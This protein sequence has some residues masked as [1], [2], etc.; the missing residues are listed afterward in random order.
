MDNLEENYK[1]KKLKD[2]NK[3]IDIIITITIYNSFIL[4]F[5]ENF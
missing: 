4:F 2:K 5:N 1:L 3:F